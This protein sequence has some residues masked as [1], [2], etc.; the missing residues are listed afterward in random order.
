MLKEKVNADNLEYVSVPKLKTELDLVLEYINDHV[1][2]LSDRV[3]HLEEC[4]AR[5]NLK[6]N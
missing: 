6:L 5:R 4:L 2:N 1:I 3:D